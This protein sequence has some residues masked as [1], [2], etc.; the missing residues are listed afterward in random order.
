[1][2][3]MKISLIQLA[4]TVQVRREAEAA[5]EVFTWKPGNGHF[6]LWGNSVPRHSIMIHAVHRET[7][8][9]TVNRW[10]DD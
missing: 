9:I 7:T 6:G 4:K 10:T 8:M 2:H 3:G 1:M 5:K